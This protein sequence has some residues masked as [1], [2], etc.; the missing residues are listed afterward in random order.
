VALSTT[1]DQIG[2]VGAWTIIGVR[3]EVVDVVA[4]R[5]DPK[6]QPSMEEARYISSCRLEEVT[7]EKLARAI[8]RHWG[9]IE[10]GS[11]HRRDV[12]FHEDASRIHHTGAAQVMATLRN[13]ALGLYELNVPRHELKATDLD[14]VGEAKQGFASWRRKLTRREVIDYFRN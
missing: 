7:E 1:P 9:A 13:L 4:A 12:T 3:R 10:N 5:K 6:L 14:G 2:L 8:Q 11:H